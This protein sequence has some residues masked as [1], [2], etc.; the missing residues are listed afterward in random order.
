[1]DLKKVVR[2]I[3]YNEPMSKH[4]TFRVGGPADIFAEPEAHELLDLIRYLNESGQ[5]YTV[6]GNG[7]N[8]LVGDKGIRGV[9]VALK[10]GIGDIDVEEDCEIYAGAGALL[11]RV[12]SEAAACGLTGLEFASGIPGSVGGAIA[13][14]AGAYDGE[15]KDVVSYVNAI[16]DNEFVKYGCNEMDFSYRHSRILDSGDIVVGVCIKLAFGDMGTIRAKMSELNQRRADKQ[17][18][19]LP[20]AGSTF[21]RPEGYFAGKLIQDA[22]LRG[23]RVGGACVSEKHCGFV[24]N[25]QNATA[26]EIKQL[27]EDVQN[28]VFEDAGVRLETEVRMI[29]EF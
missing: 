13:M 22:G 16:H 24:V 10:D 9:V 6:I 4:T 8:L 11:S 23:Y 21:K 28:K 20:S 17:P 7:S 1:M 27:I 12:A 18:I 29:G 2:N 3:K 19:N 14:N 5:P 15:M 25:D 26:A